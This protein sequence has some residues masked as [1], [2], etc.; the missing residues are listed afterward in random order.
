[1]KI[2]IISQYYWP[3]SFR[4]NDL[5]I[6]LKTSGHEVSVLTG[7][8]NYPSG[9]LFDGYNWNSFGK[10]T[11]EG[12]TILRVPLLPRKKGKPWQLILNYFSFVFFS[13]LY[14][15]FLCRDKYD[16]IFVFEPSPFTVGIPGTF[17]RFLKNAPMIFW[18]QDLWPE[19]IEATGAI[20][21]PFLLSLVGRMVRFIYKRCDRVLI[22]SRSFEVPVI[23]AGANSE[24]II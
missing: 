23:K 3:E 12:I 2:L 7:L 22:Q 9:R 20:R 5:A 17:F 18:V 8:P 10:S 14:G 1:M 24:K 16:L 4:I 19:S 13:C 15:P 11:Y 6:G 21:S